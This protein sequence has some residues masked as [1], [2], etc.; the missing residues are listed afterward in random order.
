M[1]N[2]RVAIRLI[3]RSDL[4]EIEAPD[5]GWFPKYLS[6]E[7]QDIARHLHSFEIRFDGL[8]DREDRHRHAATQRERVAR[9]LGDGRLGQFHLVLVESQPG[10]RSRVR[11]YKGIFGERVE[12][13]VQIEHELEDGRTLLIGAAPWNLADERITRWVSDFTRAFLLGSQLAIAGELHALLN[14]V[15]A[16]LTVRQGV[17]ISYIKLVPHLCAKGYMVWCSGID[18]RGQYIN[19]KGFAP[20]DQAAVIREAVEVAIEETRSD[21]DES[22]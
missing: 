16:R 22:N 20:R 21:D 18:H 8:E 11:S 1:N 3:E 17:H 10:Y 2:T 9:R 6:A 19:L 5:I 7:D 14:A 15:V 12:G 4:H 13:S